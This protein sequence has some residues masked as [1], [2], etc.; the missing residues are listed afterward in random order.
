MPAGPHTAL[1]GQE[2][3]WYATG[4]HVGNEELGNVVAHLLRRGGKSL[5][6]T[7]LLEDVALDDTNYLL[8]VD[9][10]VVL[11]NPVENVDNGYWL[12]A[13]TALA[14]FK[15]VVEH[16]RERTVEVVELDNDAAGQPGCRSGDAT[17][18]RQRQAALVGTLDDVGGLDDKPVHSAVDT[19]AQALSHV[20]EVHVLIFYL[21]KVDMLTE[22]LVRR[23]RSPEFYGM[24]QRHVALDAL[25]TRCAGE[26]SD[27]EGVAGLML[28]D[29]TFRQLAEHSLWVAVG[30]ESTYGYV[31]TVVNKFCG[32]RGRHPCVC[33]ND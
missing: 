12:T 2:L 18:R 30:C 16:A 15:S 31:V 7:G 29:G 32:L 22:I 11:A 24:G 5:E 10:Y 9:G 14:G 3:R 21:L 28:A 1:D 20:A 19:M 23:E 25:T 17:G 27:L 26:D 13:E 6:L 33:H 4:L 8:R